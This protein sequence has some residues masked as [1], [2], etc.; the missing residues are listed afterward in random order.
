VNETTLALLEPDAK[1]TVAVLNG[2]SAFQHRLRSMGLKEGKLLRVVA[3][4]HLSG[5]L[6]VEI[7][8][9]QITIGRGMAQKIVVVRVP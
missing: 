9:R 3:R 7:E 4:H 8:R 5:P 1:A 2:S 6:V